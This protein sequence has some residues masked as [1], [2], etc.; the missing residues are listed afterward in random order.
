MTDSSAGPKSAVHVKAIEHEV[1]G[2]ASGTLAHLDLTREGDKMLEILQNSNI[3]IVGGGRV[4][5]AI[6]K[7][8]A[9]IAVLIQLLS[10]SKKRNQVVAITGLSENFKK[11]FEMV[12]ITRFAKIFDHEEDA[13]NSLSQIG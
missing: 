8:G 5:K 3:A 7:I 10:E 11:I 12:G 9:G 6:L 4:C 2:Q 13:I 1:P